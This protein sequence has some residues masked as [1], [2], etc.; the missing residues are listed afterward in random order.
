MIKD[1]AYV[2]PDDD[3]SRAS[4]I[5]S[6]IGLPLT[7]H[8]DFWT[9]VKGDFHTKAIH[10][11]LTR[12]TSL[13]EVQHLRLY[14]TSFVQ[15]NPEEL[16]TAPSECLPSGREVLV[17]RPSAVY[18]WILRTML[19]YPKWGSD[20]T[21][22]N[23]DLQ[24]LHDYH[25][26]RI[27]MGFVSFKDSPELWKKLNMDERVANVQSVINEWKWDDEWREGEEWF[28]DALAAIAAGKGRIDCLPSSN[29]F[30]V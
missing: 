17:P 7:P 2:V 21:T 23:S 20:R 11:R 30:P 28:G 3:I 10:H 27:E 25:L 24:E 12:S 18:A 16:Y 5:L 4:D 29:A 9:F 22:L 13:A 26:Y 8:S 1:F 6:S 15:L 14:P 19:K